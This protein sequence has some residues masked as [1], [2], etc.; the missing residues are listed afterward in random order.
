MAQQHRGTE[1]GRRRESH[2]IP[3]PVILAHLWDAVIVTDTDGIVTYWND[4]AARLFGWTADEMIGRKYA[5]R[6]PQSERAW[7]EEQMA[8]RGRGAEFEGPYLDFRK[9]GSRVWIDARVRRICDDTGRTIGILGV[10]RDISD[11]ARAEA[12]LTA[13]EEFERDVLDS[14]AA[15]VA[16]VDRDG[17]ITAANKAWERSASV[18]G[19][20]SNGSLGDNYLEICRRR[21]HA[22]STPWSAALEGISDVLRSR[23][24]SFTLEYPLESEQGTLWFALAVTPLGECG[25]S[26]VV[27]HTDI[28]EIV[29][30][31]HVL[32]GQNDVL[33]RIASGADLH[34][35]LEEVV[36]LVERQLPGALCSILIRDR[37][38]DTLRFGAGA[39]LPSSYN[40]AVDGVPIGARSGSCGTAAFRR[41]VVVVT[42]IAADPLWDDYRGIAMQ[43]HLRS[44][45]SIPIFAAGS[46][47][48]RQPSEP[49][50][51]DGSPTPRWASTDPRH[52]ESW[53]TDRADTA[54]D[55]RVL[56]TFALYRATPGDPVVGSLRI[57]GDAAKLA[58]LA[59]ERDEVLNE[60]LRSKERLQHSQ[61]LEAIGQLASGVAHDFNNL[62][63][64]INGNAHLLLH[65]VP[66]Q[67][68]RHEALVAILT[69]GERA[70]GLTGQLLAFSR[71]SIVEPKVV[72]LNEAISSTSRM[73]RRLIEEDVNLVTNLSPSRAAV[74]IDPGQ[75]ER[76]IMNLALNARDA[77]PDGGRLTMETTQVAIAP[78][79]SEFGDLKP[80]AYVRLMVADTGAGM[81]EAV[82][83][84][85]FEPF[86]TTKAVGKGTG[87]GLATVYGIVRQA[88]GNITVQ[89]APGRGTAFSVF[90]PTVQDALGAPAATTVRT[91]PQ[92]SETVLVVEDEDGVRRLTCSALASR[93]YVVLEA[94][95][96]PDAVRIARTHPHPIDLLVTD[97]V[98]P[99]IGGRA[100]ADAILETRPSIKVLYMSGYMDDAIVRRGVETATEAFLP[101]PFTPSGLARKV[102]DV[103]DGAP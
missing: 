25:S 92:G 61:K 79:D 73:L 59:I 63:T 41:E 14:M 44:C 81:S 87:L 32:V 66:V 11:R 52:D 91:M 10:S 62:L 18:N 40:A 9:D 76:V 86:F 37:D 42:D 78:G 1:R 69:A 5:D 98:M 95:S 60:L 58:G 34:S 50:P 56:G 48:P 82:R 80:G 46:T 94:A 19:V 102:R 67:D 97:V 27:S 20:P 57:L 77:M 36:R 68:P 71:K 53:G 85:V 64:I 12:A 17:V 22:G 70:A 21:A 101:K 15:Q 55:D 47:A 100:L 54:R 16:V 83:N 39:S 13:K 26:V 103:L 33:A 35:V 90:L 4:G 72:D 65:D 28:T 2:S 45:L 89:S 8:S 6:F 84:R 75:L 23:R 30:A 31:R 88:G 3:D 51:I 93:G 24:P 74:R 99:Q 7:I 49:D 96:A 38:N 43:H 29:R